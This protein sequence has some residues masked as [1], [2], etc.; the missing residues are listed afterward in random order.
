MLNVSFLSFL[1]E[2]ELNSTPAILIYDQK[3]KLAKRFDNDDANS[4]K[5]EFSMK[6]V[7]AL[8]ERLLKN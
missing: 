7:E 1:E 8:M 6:D 2:I 4:E 3:G 5:D